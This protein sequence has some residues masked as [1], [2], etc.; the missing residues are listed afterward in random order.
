[1]EGSLV[2]TV[3]ELAMGFIIG[4]RRR[5]LIGIEEETGTQIVQG[6]DR[7]PHFYVKGNDADQQYK[8]KLKIKENAVSKI[9]LRK[10]KSKSTIY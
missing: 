1:M 6:S 4:K 8:A 9:Q 5:N 3:P 10:I 2:V 7:K